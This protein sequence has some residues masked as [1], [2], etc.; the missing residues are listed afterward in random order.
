MD[1]TLSKVTISRIV[2][3]IY[4]HTHTHTHTLRHLLTWSYIDHY[5][6]L[7][8][9]VCNWTDTKRNESCK[10]KPLWSLQRAEYADLLQ[11]EGQL[12]KTSSSVVSS[13]SAHMTGDNN[14]YRQLQQPAKRNKACSS[15][16]R[17]K[18]ASQSPYSH[19]PSSPV[20][21]FIEGLE[22][23]Q[24]VR[25]QEAD[26]E[27]QYWLRCQMCLLSSTCSTPCTDHHVDGPHANY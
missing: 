11:T 15:T 5:L 22:K 26:G 14:S 12:P 16:K 1:N 27:A 4:L 21:E 9:F 18:S 10:E 6:H 19:K 20:E 17:R 24:E 2:V 23:L 7:E 25:G 8:S 13:I 3:V